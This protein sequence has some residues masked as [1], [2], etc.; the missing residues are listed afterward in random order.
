MSRFAPVFALAAGLLC[1]AAFSQSNPPASPSPPAPQA[2]APKASPPAE[3]PTPCV[4]TKTLDD[5]T[6]AIDAA[7]SGPADKD[8]TCLRQ[9]FY[10]DSRLVP[11]GKSREGT[12]APHVLT[13]DGWIEAMQK[14]GKTPFYERQVKVKTETFGH[15]AQLW[16]TYEIRSEP[17]GKAVQRGINNIQ[18]VFD[19]TRWRVTQIV[20][21]TESPTEH[22]PETYLP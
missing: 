8:R 1:S 5:L 4:D 10:L 2:A 3:P 18:A 19:G 21:Q 14:R 11:V 17:E 22:I 7:I 20:W 6:K 13:I 15:I 16:S 12:Y 9:L